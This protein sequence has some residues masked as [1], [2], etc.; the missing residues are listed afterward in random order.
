M[1]EACVRSMLRLRTRDIADLANRGRCEKE[2]SRVYV[3]PGDLLAKLDIASLSKS[4]WEIEEAGE[5]VVSVDEAER[6]RDAVAL[7]EA[8]GTSS[9]DPRLTDAAAKLKA[10]AG[11]RTAASALVQARH[12]KAS[13]PPPA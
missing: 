7:L 8:A 4:E 9:G 3:D 6:V 12:S 11:A 10:K 1:N 5:E 2:A 13:A